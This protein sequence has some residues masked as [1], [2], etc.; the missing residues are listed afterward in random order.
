MHSNT[1]MFNF[2][3]QLRLFIGQ[4]SKKYPQKGKHLKHIQYDDIKIQKLTPQLSKQLKHVAHDNRVDIKLYSRYNYI[5]V[6]IDLDKTNNAISHKRFIEQRQTEERAT[7][8]SVNTRRPNKETGVESILG[9][10]LELG[11][12][13]NPAWR[14]PL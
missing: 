2:D 14:V 6:S 8:T 4:V 10:A 11:F 7:I 12:T 9:M 13:H 1:A 3:Y 5:T